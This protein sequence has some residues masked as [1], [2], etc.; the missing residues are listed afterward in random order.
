MA[1][2][3]KYGYCQLC[4]GPIKE[5]QHWTLTAMMFRTHNEPDDCIWHLHIQRG[6]AIAT[7]SGK[8][9]KVSK[10]DCATLESN[11]ANLDRDRHDK[12]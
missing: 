12:K 8:P 3:P 9:C 10:A 6:Q 2:K 11:L 7:G 1:S 5:G 4:Q